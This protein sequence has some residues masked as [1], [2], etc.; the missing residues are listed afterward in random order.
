MASWVDS[1]DMTEHQLKQFVD[2]CQRRRGDEV[3]RALTDAT[4]AF[5]AGAKLNPALLVEAAGALDDVSPAAAAWIALT[6]GTSVERGTDPEITGPGLLS[7]FRNVLQRLPTSSEDLSNEHVDATSEQAAILEVFPQLCQ[8]VVA[9]I[10]RLPEQRELLARDREH[11]DRLAELEQFGGSATWVREAI[12]KTSGSLVLLHPQSG[13]GVRL[14][15]AN[16]SNCF[17]LVS[18]LQTAVGRRIPGGRSVNDGI[19]AAARGKTD[20]AV[21]DEA[22]WHYGDPRSAEPTLSASIWGEA[23]ARS[24]PVVNGVQTILLWPPILASR[25]WDSGFF[26][27]RIE[28]LPSDAA[29][30]RVLSQSEVAELLDGLGVKAPR[31]W[32]QFW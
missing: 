26:G 3:T 25:K 2:F 14:R 7:Y 24:I 20:Q 29:I 1:R 9:H 22:W 21:H 31:K 27:P 10:A 6:L 15:Y 19:A 12:L 11:L 30:D 8:A 32:W 16:V 13:A 18:L 5:L 4:S 17:H 28:A 23:L